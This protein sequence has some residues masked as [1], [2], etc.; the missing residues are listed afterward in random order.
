MKQL[1]QRCILCIAEVTRSWFTA[2]ILSHRSLEVCFS[3][4]F[5]RTGIVDKKDLGKQTS[6]QQKYRSDAFIT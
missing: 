5:Q 4:L 1:L 6:D 3:F 2:V